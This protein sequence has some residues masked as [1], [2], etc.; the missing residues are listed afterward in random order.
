MNS[1]LET[2]KKMI[3][4]GCDYTEFDVDLIVHINSVFSLLAQLGAGK[5]FSIDGA[6][7]TW[8]DYLGED[9]TNLEMLKT[10][11]Y[12]KIRLVF[13]PPSSSSVLNSMKEF[14]SEYEWRINV[15]SETPI[16]N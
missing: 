14:V 13:D 7:Q 5:V 15:E 3:G 12:M 9:L 10:Y 4:F 2:I 16:D 11:M 6:D 1:I 8:G